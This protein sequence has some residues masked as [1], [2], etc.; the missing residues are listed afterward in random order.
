[1]A[2]FKE[3]KQPHLESKK[4][5]VGHPGTQCKDRQLY[6]MYTNCLPLCVPG[7]QMPFA[8]LANYSDHFW[9]VYDWTPRP[10]HLFEQVLLPVHTLV[11]HIRA[12][13]RLILFIAP[14]QKK[15]KAD[16][17][18]LPCWHL[19]SVDFSLSVH[20]STCLS[21]V[22]MSVRL[23][24]WLLCGWNLNVWPWRIFQTIFGTWRSSLFM[25]TVSTRRVL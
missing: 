21:D 24:I 17:K 19:A 7:S 12:Q 2:F 15:I 5:L 9:P 14:R 4:K 16:Y 8:A 20:L 10:Y 13:P 11:L 3:I 18:P 1:M 22:L 6:A 23:F 25:P